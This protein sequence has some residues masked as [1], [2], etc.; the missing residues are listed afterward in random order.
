M[1]VQHS[2]KQNASLIGRRKFTLSRE[3]R[4]NAGCCGYSP[5]QATGLAMKR[6]GNAFTL[7]PLNVRYHQP[8]NDELNKVRLHG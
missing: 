4:Y 5:K 7:A 3:L 8:S 6:S 1:K 2:I